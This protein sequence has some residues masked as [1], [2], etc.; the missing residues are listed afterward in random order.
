LSAT[1]R[2]AESL[3]YADAS[4]LVKLV[5]AEAESDALEQYL[6][7]RGTQLI[8]SRIAVVEVTRAATLSNEALRAEAEAL[9]ASCVL[10]DVGTAILEHASALASAQLRSLD[11]IHLATA[12]D[13]DPDEMIVYDLRLAH[14]AEALGLRVAA[15]GR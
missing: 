12:L 3:T 4:A 2:A 13:V 11:A 15:P 8:S 1:A 9:L 7:L 14:A 6:E 10:V 5:A